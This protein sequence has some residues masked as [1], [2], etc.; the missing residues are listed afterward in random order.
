MI[1]SAGFV[2]VDFSAQ[3]PLAL[4]LLDTFSQWDFPKGHLEKGETPLTAAFRETREECGLTRADFI[5]TGRFV[6]T[7]P[8]KVPAGQKV[9]TY[10]FAERISRTD[11]TL[12]INPELGYPEHESFRWIPVKSLYSVMSRRLYPVLVELEEWCENA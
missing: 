7:T 5:P 1:K 6:S 11:P 10:F 9:A 8:Y 3:E 12:P 4:C 2:I